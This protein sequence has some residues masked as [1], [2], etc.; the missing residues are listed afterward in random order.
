[1][2]TQIQLRRGKAA[3]WTDE[4]PVLHQGE[5]GYETD[6]GM[7]KIGDGLTFW[8]DLEYFTGLDLDPGTDDATAMALITAHLSDTTPHPVYDDGPSLVLIYENAKV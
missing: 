6:T 3:F 8:R 4:N 5:P 7:L 1:M 2:A